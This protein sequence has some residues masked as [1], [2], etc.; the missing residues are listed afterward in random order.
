M[1]ERDNDVLDTTLWTQ[2]EIYKVL[3]G[4]FYPWNYLRGLQGSHLVSLREAQYKNTC[5]WNLLVLSLPPYLAQ[6]SENVMLLCRSKEAANQD[7]KERSIFQ[8][9]SEGSQ[10]P[11]ISPCWERL[12]DRAAALISLSSKARMLA[13]KGL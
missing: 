13:D 2:D 9:F 4:L 5:L 10:A 1:A 11:N 7:R 12:V 6:Q 8:S 3:L